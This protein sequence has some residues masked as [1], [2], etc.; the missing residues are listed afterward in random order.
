MLG[1]RRALFSSKGKLP[2]TELSYLRS[3]GTQWINTGIIGSGDISVEISVV[4]N[5]PTATAFLIG[6]RA[7]SSS[8]MY[9]LV[10]NIGTIRSD[11]YLSNTMSKAIVGNQ[12]YVIYKNKNITYVDGVLLGSYTYNSFNNSRPMY[13]FSTNNNGS[14]TTPIQADVSY[15]KIWNDTTLVRDFVPVLRNDGVYCM[16]DKVS[17]TYFTNSG[18]GVFS[19][20]M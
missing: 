3:S 6:S 17:K 5:A 7:S 20:G 18:T 11:Y 9:V 8:N 12:K 14:V 13:L 10:T 1:M 2:H 15:C 16:Y 4:F 19:G